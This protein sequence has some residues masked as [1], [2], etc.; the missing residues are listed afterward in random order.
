MKKTLFFIPLMALLLICSCDDGTVHEKEA[1][2]T[3]GKIVKLEGHLIGLNSYPN[4]Y[5]VSVAGF[6][7]DA[8]NEVSPY[9]TISKV[10]T[11]DAD[12]NVSM[13]LS[14]ITGSVKNVELC[15][16][17]SLRQRVVT[18]VSEDISSQSV[19]DTIR[20]DVGTVDVSMLSAIQSS[21]FNVSCIGCHGANGFSGAGLNL[22][23][24]NSFA[25]LV[26]HASTKVPEKN[27]VSPGDAAHSVLYEVINDSTFSQDWRENHSDILNHERSADLISLVRDWIN[28]G[29]AQ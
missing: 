26:S 4:R 11:A 10:V 1:S 14:G 18:F 2:M 16:L 28:S 8:D 3:T 23:E 13:V 20:I 9:A 12:G 7:E 29:A 5:D 25:Q 15:V 24:G 27:R 21:L 19:D 6:S 17:N 22:T